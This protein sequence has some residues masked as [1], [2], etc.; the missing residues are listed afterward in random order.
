MILKGKT[1]AEFPEVLELLDLE[2][3]NLT[4]ENAK[5]IKAGSSDKKYWVHYTENN[6][7]HMWTSSVRNVCNGTRCRHNVCKSAK[8]LK[9]LLQKPYNGLTLAD[10]PDVLTYL[11]I[12]ANDFTLEEAKLFRSGTCKIAKWFHIASDGQIHKWEAPIREL[13]NGIRCPQQVCWVKKMLKTKQE[14][15]HN[16]LTLTDF[17]DI[18]ALLDLE[19]NGFSEQEGKS[20][21]PCTN[22]IFHWK[23]ITNDGEIHRW[24]ARMGDIKSGSR[25]PHKSCIK[26]RKMET[27]LLKHGKPHPSINRKPRR[28]KKDTPNP[29]SNPEIIAKIREGHIKKYGCPHPM[30][31]PQVR[32]KA[33]MTNLA[34]RGVEY[35]SQDPVVREK[36][37]KTWKTKYGTKGPMGNKVLAKKMRDTMFKRYNVV[38]SMQH[39]PSAEKGLRKSGYKSYDHTASDGTV[40]VGLQGYERF[41]V[42]LNIHPGVDL[43]NS[44]SKVPE[45]WYTGIDNKQHRYYMDFYHAPSNTCYEIKSTWTYKLNRD[46]LRLTKKA[47]EEIGMKFVLYVF[48]SVGRIV[49]TKCTNPSTIFDTN[50]VNMCLC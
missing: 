18:F 13:T 40:L 16:G 37:N 23:H 21:R 17:P 8:R 6:E 33:R 26:K 24:Q 38:H 31:N 15:P 41:F 14:R 49:K 11:D 5:A 44:K 27:Y 1:L 30:Q 19:E 46:K 36:M 32:E 9:T 10:F 35:T 22:Q 25:C 50:N 39:A 2:A 12:E 4:I 20:L 28:L 43:I 42:N 29:F 45:V 34:K 48:D 47:C 3:N 7:K